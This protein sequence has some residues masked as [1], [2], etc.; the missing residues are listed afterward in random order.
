MSDEANK[1]HY[2]AII[3]DTH[4]LVRPGL[5]EALEGAELII[6][7]GDV[8]SEIVLDEIETVA[9]VIAVRGNMDGY[10]SDLPITETRE[11]LNKRF[12][13]LHDLKGFNRSLMRD[14][15]IVISG[16][17]HNPRVFEENGVLF[18]NPGSAGPRRG[19]LPVCMLKLYIEGNDVSW[20]QVF[21]G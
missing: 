6:H 18:I 4:D 13:I 9:P 14:L 15:D 11:I 12:H 17:T 2:I 21:V 10:H 8:C 5:M 7:A 3:S 19:T 20:E 1:K 16:H